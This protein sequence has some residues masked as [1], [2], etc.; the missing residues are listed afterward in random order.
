M[1]KEEGMTKE[2]HYTAEMFTAVRRVLDEHA[3]LYADFPAFIEHVTDFADLVRRIK[4]QGDIHGTLSAGKADA[5]ADAK[6]RLVRRVIDVKSKLLAYARKKGLNETRAIAGVS[7]YTLTTMKE[8]E[9]RSLASNLAV[10]AEKCLPELAAYKFDQTA[11]DAFKQAIEEFEDAISDR[12]TSMA[13][14]RAKTAELEEL[15]RRAYQLL[16]EGLDSLMNTFRHDATEFYGTYKAARVIRRH[17][18][19]HDAA[20]DTPATPPA[21]PAQ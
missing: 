21:A 17:G 6:E 9:L 16:K 10:E 1:R 13:A 15:F 18:I 11:L 5:R 3:A 8:A 2:Q 14:R 7:N 4:E 19:R 20:P 12:D